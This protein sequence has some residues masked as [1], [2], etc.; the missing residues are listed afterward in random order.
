MIQLKIKIRSQYLTDIENYSYDTC[1]CKKNKINKNVDIKVRRVSGITPPGTLK[2]KIGKQFF[3]GGAI[4][5]KVLNR[6]SKIGFACL[7]EV[8]LS[9]N[10]R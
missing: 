1:Y 4:K 9:F 3:F 5:P 7:R 10:N 6:I 2:S 8:N